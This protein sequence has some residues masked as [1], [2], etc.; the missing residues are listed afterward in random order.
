MN[1]HTLMPLLGTPLVAELG[2]LHRF[3]N[4]DR[5]LLTDSGGFQMVSEIDRAK[6]IQT[7]LDDQ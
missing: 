1:T 4:W 6:R 3:M 7:V 5:N 2:G